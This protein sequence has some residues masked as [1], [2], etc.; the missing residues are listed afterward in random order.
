[1]RISDWSSDVCS[2]DLHVIASNLVE[3]AAIEKSDAL[4]NYRGKRNGINA[5]LKLINE[6]E[7]A[8]WKKKGIEKQLHNLLK[9]QPWLIR[10]EYSRYLTSDH[11]LS[12]VTT[13]LDKTLG[14]AELAAMNDLKRPDHVVFMT[15]TGVHTRK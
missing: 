4:K 7:D 11:D 13:E 14:V 8:L 3:L 6:G 15:E 9:E 1:M 5:L 10:P 12:R 2:S